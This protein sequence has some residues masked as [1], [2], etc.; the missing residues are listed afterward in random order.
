MMDTKVGQSKKEDPASVARKG[1][2]AMMAGEGEVISGWQNKLQ[3]AIA[4]VI[5]AGISAEMHKKMAAPGTGKK[6]A[7]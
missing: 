7:A 6:G 4:S 2:D 1:F 3:A 5:P